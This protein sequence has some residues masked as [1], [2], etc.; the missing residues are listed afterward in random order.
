[1]RLLDEMRES[2]YRGNITHERI[3]LRVR[4]LDENRYRVTDARGRAIEY[5]K[6]YDFTR[7]ALAIIDGAAGKEV[8]LEG[9][10]NRQGRWSI[11][12]ALYETQ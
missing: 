3:P 12:G 11:T 4:R 5:R 7:E 2:G 6:R 8:V 9:W 1:M 10:L